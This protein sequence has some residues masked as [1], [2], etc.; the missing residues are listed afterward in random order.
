A[1]AKA[2]S[3]VVEVVA[4]PQG[5]AVLA[6][7]TWSAMRGRAALKVEWDDSEAEQRSTDEIFAEYR[8]LAATP[9]LSAAKRGDAEGALKNAAKVVETEFSFPYLAH[10]PMEPLNAV[11]EIKDGNVE[12]WAGAQLQ[13]VETATAAWVLGVLPTKLK[14]NTVWAGGSF[15]RR[16]TP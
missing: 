12:I 10:A 2:V 6:K 7:D 11:I 14:L 3:G 4:I 9:G 16:A 13:T 5:V 8:R 1:D 15:G